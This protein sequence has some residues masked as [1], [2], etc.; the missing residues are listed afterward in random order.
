MID[1]D[2]KFWK[3]FMILHPWSD[4]KSWKFYINSL[5]FI[6]DPWSRPC[7][8]ICSLTT[9]ASVIKSVIQWADDFCLP[10]FLL[11]SLYFYLLSVSVPILQSH[12]ERASDEPILVS[13]LALWLGFIL[14]LLVALCRGFIVGELGSCEIQLETLCYFITFL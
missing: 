5:E 12:T 3:Y 6:S 13:I 14:E 10:S 1:V 4:C 2:C 8:V 11:F 9:L 7:K